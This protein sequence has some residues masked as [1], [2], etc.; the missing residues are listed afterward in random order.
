MIKQLML[1][2]NRWRIDAVMIE[3]Q[4]AHNHCLERFGQRFLDFKQKMR[5]EREQKN[6]F[7]KP[8]G[9]NDVVI[10]IES[11]LAPSNVFPVSSNITVF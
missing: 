7:F 5:D 2:G 9:T 1:G 10:N 8:T 6:S 3:I 11:E 4:T